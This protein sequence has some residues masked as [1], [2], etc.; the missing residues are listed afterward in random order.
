MNK[1]FAES[2]VTDL[3][4][5][6]NDEI[7]SIKLEFTNLSKRSKFALVHGVKSINAKCQSNSKFQWILNRN[8]KKNDRA[9]IEFTENPNYIIKSLKSTDVKTKSNEKPKKLTFTSKFLLLIT[10]SDLP[11]LKAIDPF[12]KSTVF[13]YIRECQHLFKHENN[14]YFI[15]PE[16]VSL[17][18]L[19]YYFINGYFDIIATEKGVTL[20][21]D[22]KTIIFSEGDS[23]WDNTSYINVQPKF[24]VP[25]IYKWFIKINKCVSTHIMIAL[26]P[27]I[28][29]NNGLFGEFDYV[30]W[31]SNGKSMI[32]ASF[33]EYGE[34]YD[35]GDE[36]TVVLNTKSKQLSFEKNGKC[37]G[38]LSDKIEYSESMKYSVGISLY[39]AKS[40]CTIRKV[41]ID[42]L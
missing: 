42:L 37:Q 30:Y 6:S 26:T 33:A 23:T 36:I 32:S 29:S 9:Q 19:K 8:G 16:L 14:P 25:A 3:Y 28:Q 17:I 2:I 15:I 41:E 13:G 38:I 5:A 39:A 35:T 12:T 20:S 22:K 21:D 31:S 7:N 27:S 10:A 4:T 24:S 1:D 40:S 11:N 34:A 18:V